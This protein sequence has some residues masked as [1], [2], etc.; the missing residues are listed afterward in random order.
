[1]SDITALG[2]GRF[3]VSDGVRQHLAYAAGP[4]EARWVFLDGQ[5]FVVDVTNSHGG[6]GRSGAAGRRRPGV[7]EG[8]DDRMAL[9]AP[10]PATVVLINVEPGQQVST[11]DV[12]IV[13]EAMKMELPIKAPRGGTVKT[14]SCTQG[15]LVQAGVPLLELD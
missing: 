14:L 2:G 6:R 11:G 7:L 15:Q 4:P 10:M 12:L 8:E 5:V 3:L 9:A 13:L 1:V